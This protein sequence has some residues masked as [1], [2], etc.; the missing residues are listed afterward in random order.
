MLGVGT[1]TFDEWNKLPESEN[2]KR[3]QKH[4]PSKPRSSAIR[5]PT[6]QYSALFGSQFDRFLPPEQW[7]LEAN[8]TCDNS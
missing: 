8:F 7:K 3:Q 5:P 1:T 4:S 6:S 2:S